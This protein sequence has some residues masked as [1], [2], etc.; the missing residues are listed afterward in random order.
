VR[1][2]CID[3]PD[4]G[5]RDPVKDIAHSG[6]VKRRRIATGRAAAPKD[7]CLHGRGVVAT[8][9]FASAL[10]VTDGSATITG[11]RERRHR[12]SRPQ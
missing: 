3:D 10:A 7:D 5:R 11:H 8:Y 4:I 2:V 12:A 9:P 6:V 1:Q